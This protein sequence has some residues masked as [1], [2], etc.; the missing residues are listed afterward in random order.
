MGWGGEKGEGGGSSGGGVTLNMCGCR[1]LRPQPQPRPQPSQHTRTCA[2]QSATEPN[3]LSV[4]AQLR[5]MATAGDSSSCSVYA[6]LLK[7]PPRHQP[8]ANARPE[9]TGAQHGCGGV[10]WGGQVC[11]QAGGLSASR[12][13]GGPAVGERLLLPPAAAPC[14]APTFGPEL[15]ADLHQHSLPPLNVEP[16]GQHVWDA[17]LRLHPHLHLPCG[18]AGEPARAVKGRTPEQGG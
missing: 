9:T 14:T 8:D 18:V 2:A 1:S 17:A 15:A 5:C 12:G 6:G 4:S 10:G 16:P 3:R 13:P 11:R 7:A